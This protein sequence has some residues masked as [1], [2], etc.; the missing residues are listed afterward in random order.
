[1]HMNGVSYR[2]GYL[3]LHR[4][5]ELIKRG[6]AL[7]KI[8]SDCRL[9]PRE[10]RVNRLERES[11]FCKASDELRVAS[12]NPHFGEERPLVG[13]GGSGTIFLSHCNLGCV[14][15]QNWDISHKGAGTKVEISNLAVMMLE[16]QEEGCSNINIV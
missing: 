14:F 11:G 4:S 16:L 13:V 12:Y 5:G 15:C 3:A 9:C 7:W 8:L 1:M 2:P 10:C 6:E